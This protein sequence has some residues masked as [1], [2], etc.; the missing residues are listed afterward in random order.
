L[1]QR[2][3]RCACKRRD[4]TAIRRRVGDHERGFQ[5]L[6]DVLNIV[7]RYVRTGQGIGDVGPGGGRSEFMKHVT[8]RRRAQPPDAADV[9]GGAERP[10]EV[11]GLLEGRRGGGGL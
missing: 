8:N 6:N 4:G 1:K 2:L 11:Q 5:F 10:G 9:Q 7:R 3:R